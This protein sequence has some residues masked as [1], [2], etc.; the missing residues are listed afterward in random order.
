MV[1]IVDRGPSQGV[2]PILYKIFEAAYAAMLGEGGDGGILLI[3]QYPDD[4]WDEGLNKF[5]WTIVNFERWLKLKGL[6]FIRHRSG[7]ENGEFVSYYSNQEGI[8]FTKN[9]RSYFN[10]HEYMYEYKWEI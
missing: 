9:N 10:S 7:S 1:D 8:V 3:V 4:L 6:D 2:D 5:E